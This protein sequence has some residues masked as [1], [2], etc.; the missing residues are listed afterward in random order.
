MKFYYGPVANANVLTAD[1]STL[2]T[3]AASYMINNI[4]ILAV[5]PDTLAHMQNQSIVLAN[6]SSNYA[7]GN[8]TL[9]VTLLYKRTTP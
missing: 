8:G 5:G 3:E 2:I 7:A 6:S 4:P 1:Y 9:T